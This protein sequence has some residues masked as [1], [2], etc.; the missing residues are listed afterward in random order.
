MPTNKSMVTPTGTVNLTEDSQ[1]EGYSV[2]RVNANTEKIADAVTALTNTLFSLTASYATKKASFITGNCAYLKIGNLVLVVISDVVITGTVPSGAS[3]YA[4]ALFEGL[5]KIK[6]RG[7]TF[8]ISQFSNNRVWRLSTGNNNNK[9]FFA[10]HYDN[11]PTSP[12]QYYGIFWYIT[13]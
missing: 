9:A 8:A 3:A 13:E 12:A 1:S 10:P 4:N 6:N 11:P 5:P 7:Q 2:D